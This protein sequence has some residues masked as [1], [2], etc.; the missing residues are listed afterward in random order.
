MSSLNSALAHLRDLFLFIVL[1]EINLLLCENLISAQ[2]N[3]LNVRYSADNNI[4]VY[5]FISFEKSNC[6]AFVRCFSLEN[7]FSRI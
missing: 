5:K 4:F 7:R 6:S 2:V 3:T 1:L